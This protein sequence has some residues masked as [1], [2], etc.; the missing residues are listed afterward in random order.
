MNNEE[1]ARRRDEVV[2]RMANTPP[3]P[4]PKKADSVSPKKELNDGRLVQILR[5]YAL[6]PV[7]A[8]V[9]F[10]S[11]RR[12]PLKARAFADYLSAA[13]MRSREA[14]MAAIHHRPGVDLKSELRSPRRADR[15][16]A[17]E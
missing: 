10:P 16:Q 15:A 1:I 6:E 7:D 4:K 14:G 8:H 5:D 13:L 12:A 3:Q 2:R 11:G 17:G 9:V